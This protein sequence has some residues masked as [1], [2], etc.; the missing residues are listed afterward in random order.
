MTTGTTALEF[1]TPHIRQR[2]RG[3]K[4]ELRFSLTRKGYAAL[5]VWITP[6]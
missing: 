2:D 1:L 6:G 3:N 5:L 4:K